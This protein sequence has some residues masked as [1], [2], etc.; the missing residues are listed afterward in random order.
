MVHLSKLCAVVCSAFVLTLLGYPQS[1][2]ATVSVGGGSGTLTCSSGGYNLNGSGP[3]SGGTVC[4]GP[5]P[6]FTATATADSGAGAGHVVATTTSVAIGPAA[7]APVYADAVYSDYFI[8]HSSSP[9]TSTSVSLNLNVAG[10]MSAGA[11]I[12]GG[13]TASVYMLTYI[14]GSQ[15]GLLSSSIDSNGGTS[16]TSTFAGGCAGAVFG[17]GPLVTSS[18]SVPLDVAVLLELYLS[19]GTTASAT[20][21]S[22]SSEF[23]NSLDFPI[24]V[25]LFNL[26]PG[27]TV[28]APDSFV[29]N[30]IFAPPT[31]A[32]PLPAALPLFA[33]GLGAL[34]LIG[35]RRKRKARAL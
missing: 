7:Q 27:V 33:T 18:V 28:N 19:V 5:A 3:L 30:N 17:P 21:S 13:A 9:G 24:G 4:T 31:A 34:G 23:G 2:A 1:S 26:D 25:A 29:F 6:N 15:V 8:F 10:T 35:L 11:P 14:N 22:A 20:G 12:A 16:C 32:T